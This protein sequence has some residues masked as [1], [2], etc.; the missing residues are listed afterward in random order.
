M[1]AE[2]V[3][4]RYPDPQVL[5]TGQGGPV[6]FATLEREHAEIAEE[7]HGVLDRVVGR[8]AFILG[9]EVDRFEAAWAAACGTAECVGVA[10]GTAALSLVLRAAGIGQGDEVIVPAHTYIAS[11]LAVLHAGAVPVLC[12]V[13]EGTGLLDVDAA[14][15]VVGPRTAAVLPVHLYGQLCEMQAVRRL[16]E[17]HG[18]AL[19]EDAA[20]AHGAECSGQ[21]A[22]T[23]GQGAAFSFYPSKNLGALGDAGAICT[24]DRDLAERVRRLRNLGQRRKGE[25]V[26]PGANERLD[27]LQAAVL[28][29]KLR[30][31][32]S[33][34]AAR[35]QHAASY[36]SVLE[37][38]VRMLDERPATPCVY[39]LFPVR[40]PRR[41]DVRARLRAAGIGT[42][43]HYSPPLHRQPALQGLAVAPEALP[44]AEAWAREELSLPMSPKLRPTEIST[45]AQACAAAVA[46]VGAEENG[47]L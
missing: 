37:G 14:A 13:E 43:V 24:N 27:G 2:A 17:R 12:D 25:H 10:S 29:L 8:S 9:D 41:D 30:R 42:G 40:V 45:A 23:F 21:R 39:H 19:F 18:L 5:P 4:L 11:A 20:Q 47:R 26:V 7:L 44:R 34:N 35:R 16:A 3:S 31:L 28:G 38:E 15:A 22:G 36:R 32:D 1:P 6:P 46:G 33:A